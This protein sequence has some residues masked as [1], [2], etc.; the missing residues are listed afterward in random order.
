MILNGQSLASDDSELK[1]SNQVVNF[2]VVITL[3]DKSMLIWQTRL[4]MILF[5][6][7]KGDISKWMDKCSFKLCSKV[8]LSM[9]LSNSVEVMKQ[10][11]SQ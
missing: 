2:Q 6:T 8:S 5:Q 4:L 9:L 10:I 1:R 11:V 7:I 3:S